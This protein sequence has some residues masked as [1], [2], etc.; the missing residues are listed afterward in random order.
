[1]TKM[2]H[3]GEKEFSLQIKEG[4]CAMMPTDALLGLALYPR[5][6]DASRTRMARKILER[7]NNNLATLFAD[8]IHDFHLTTGLDDYSYQSFRAMRELL[9]RA[10]CQELCEQES[11]S[12]SEKTRKLLSSK[13]RFC[14]IELFVCLYLNSKYRLISFEEH[15]AGTV[16]GTFVH[17]REIVK[18]SLELGAH[19][20]IIAHNHPSGEV[21]PSSSDI[22]ITNQLLEAL[23][24]VEVTLL[25]HLIVGG[26]NII[27]FAEKDLL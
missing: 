24:L 2:Y 27:S 20:L 25:D 19:A 9:E 21:E 11:L 22:S 15:T 5:R 26:N 14:K 8:R 10:I 16:N 7:A 3:L 13:L 4:G 18:R 1:M 6:A 17:P 23:K 12:S